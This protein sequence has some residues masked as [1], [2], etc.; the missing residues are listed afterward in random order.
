LGRKATTTA[1]AV[2]KRSGCE[3]PQAKVLS[4]NTMTNGCISHREACQGRKNTFWA[5]FQTA[6]VRN[7]LKQSPKDFARGRI[8]RDFLAASISRSSMKGCVDF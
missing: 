5:C 8:R 3:S 6:G 1:R 2:S 7:C 4:N